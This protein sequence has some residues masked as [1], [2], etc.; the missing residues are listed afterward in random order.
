MVQYAKGRVSKEFEIRGRNHMKNKVFSH[1]IKNV[2]KY[3]Y[4]FFALILMFFYTSDFVLNCDI[5]SHYDFALKLPLLFENGLEWFTENVKYAHILS[6]PGWHVL[7]LIAYLLFRPGA[8]ANFF[9]Y[10]YCAVLASAVVNTFFSLA[11]IYV[12][13]LGLQ[14]CFDMRKKI[15]LVISSVLMFVGPLYVPILIPNYYLGQFTANPWHNPTTI[16]VEPFSVACFF[17]FCYV[18]KE[19][20]GLSE[21]KL[22][23][24]LGELSILLVLS[25]FFKP[26]FYQSFVP[27]VAA[28]IVLD[29]CFFKTETFKNNI[30]CMFALLPVSI[31]ALFQ[32]ILSFT[33]TSNG[34]VIKPF[35]VWLLYSKNPLVSFFCSYFFLFVAAFAFG[36]EHCLQERTKISTLFVFSSVSQFVLF[37]FEKGVGAADFLWGVYLASYCAFLVAMVSLAEWIENKGF[38]TRA[39]ITTVALL[40][41]FISGLGYFIAIF[42]VGSYKL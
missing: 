7:F 15:A 19:K 34:I 10:E 3:Y 42:L 28:Y 35:E 24:I 38:N 1:G 23:I 12:T 39:K 13:V 21:K 37:S 18:R 33:G 8:V 16:A 5:K 36:Q 31:L 41:H 17:L 14:R 25:A 20:N 11:T 4:L 9:S 27:A 22:H 26:S 30:K 29:I 32:Y 6:Y 2:E 40:C